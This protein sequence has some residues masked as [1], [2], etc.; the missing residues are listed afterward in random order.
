MKLSAGRVELTQAYVLHHQPWRDT[1]RILEVFARD[2]GRLSLFARG[3]R[4]PK[5]RSASALQPFVPLLVSWS[6]RGEAANLG[7]VESAADAGRPSPAALPAAALMSAWYMNELLLK[8]THRHDPQPGLY[9]SYERALDALRAGAALPATL[10]RFELELLEHLG[11]GLE[12]SIDARSGEP[13]VAEARYHYH[14]SLGFVRCEADAAIGAV[15]GRSVQALA[16]AEFDDAD[17]LEDARRILRGAID[18][19]L[20]GRELRTR[21]VARSVQRRT[22]GAERSS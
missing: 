5:S 22:A 4:G 15:S 17:A 3:V 13:M 19:A 8:L 7:K 18:Q 20:E 2:H 16:R 1:S 21:D 12:C 9:A 6:G 14:A 11:Y 10:R